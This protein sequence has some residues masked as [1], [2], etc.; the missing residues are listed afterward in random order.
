ML[1]KSVLGAAV[2]AATALAD[3]TSVNN[4]L[5]KINKDIGSLNTTINGWDGQLFSAIPILAQSWGL[6]GTIKSGT[7][8]AD[9]S[10]PLNFDETLVIADSTADVAI[11]AHSILANM[12]ATKP[13]FDKI[14]VG[15]PFALGILKNLRNE[16]AALATSIISKV[17]AELQPIA[18]ELVG[19]ID[20]DFAAAVKTYGG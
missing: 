8:T 13:K 7:K 3:L 12:V 18:K 5:I 15:T 16:T 4:A 17:P 9:S 1:V 6:E 10:G 2:F 14:I 19:G 11:S 20:A